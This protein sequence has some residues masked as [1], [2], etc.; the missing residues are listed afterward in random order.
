M[1][2]QTRK[3]WGWGVVENDLGADEVRALGK[4]MEQGLTMV[5]VIR[6]HF[7]LVFLFRLAFTRQIAC[8]EVEFGRLTGSRSS[9]TDHTSVSS[10][11]R[12]PSIHAVLPPATDSGRP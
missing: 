3:F 1:S 10:R 7:E 9:V 5:R 11:L 6:H 4:R 8:E 2:T 12:T